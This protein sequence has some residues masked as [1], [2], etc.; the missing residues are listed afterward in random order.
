MKKYS[1]VILFFLILLVA[2]FSESSH[3][4]PGPNTKTEDVKFAGGVYSKSLEVLDSTGYT[5]HILLCSL[6][7]GRVSV[8]ITPRGW[9]DDRA[10]AYVLLPS[11]AYPPGFLENIPKEVGKFRM[12]NT[13]ISNFSYENGMIKYRG[14]L[15][16]GE[17]TVLSIR[18]VFREP[19]LPKRIK[20]SELG[21]SEFALPDVTLKGEN[22]SYGLEVWV[23]WDYGNWSLSVLVPRRLG[24]NE[25]YRLELE[26]YLSSMLDGLKKGIQPLGALKKPDSK[27]PEPPDSYCAELSAPGDL[28]YT[29]RPLDLSGLYSD[30][31][32]YES[33]FSGNS[34]REVTMSLSAKGCSPAVWVIFRGKAENRLTGPFLSSVHIEARGQGSVW[35]SKIEVVDE[36][37]VEPILH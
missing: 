36:V 22:R 10:A 30:G 9:I 7:G 33:D 6:A 17:C 11:G 8:N 14:Y 20:V 1:V 27:G 18:A 24:R 31:A 15:K 4:T 3:N 37:V 29:Q 23:P 19:G 35:S 34:S 12:V 5:I 13:T 32:Y 25:T 16:K 26:N 21:V 2:I 28:V